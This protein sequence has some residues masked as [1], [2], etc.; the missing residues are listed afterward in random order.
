MLAQGGARASWRVEPSQAGGFRLFKNGDQIRRDGNGVFGDVDSPLRITYEPYGSVV[1]VADKSNDYE[2]GRLE[3]GLY[4]ST[5]CDSGFCLRLVVQLSMQKYLLGLAE[6]PSSWP[7]AVLRAQAMAGRTYA[8][9]KRER[10]GSHRYPCDCTVYDSTIDQAYAGNG[11]RVGSDGVQTPEDH[12]EDWSEA[13]VATDGKII[14]HNGDPIQALYSS[15]SGGHTENNENVWGG[16]PLPFLRGVPDKPDA[17]SINPNHR[18]DPVTLSWREFSA[19]V[20]ND[21]E[22]DSVGNLE[23]FRIVPPRGVSGR[24]TVTKSATEG[25][26]RLIGSAGTVRDSGWGF[27]TNFGSDILLDTLFYIEIKQTV[28]EQ[29]APT[30]RR[31]DGA[32]GDAL[33]A[34]Y[35]VPKGADKPLGR[36]QNFEIGRMTWRKATDKTVW[37]WGRVL[38]KY[39]NVGRERSRLGMPTSNVWGRE[40]RFWGGSYANG[41]IFWSEKTGA[42]VVRDAFFETFSEVGG[43]PRMGL[44]TTDVRQTE[45]NGRLQRFLNGTLYKPPRRAAVYALWGPIDERYRELGMGRSRCGFPTS[46]MVRDSSGAAV[47]FQNGSI[48]YSAGA[49]VKV[50]CD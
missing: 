32:P 30:Y 36:A 24:V 42:H 47:A 33:A 19:R 2:L 15:S 29:F 5:A 12:F 38:R 3:V 50:H 6:V 49:G 27:R 7:Q 4:S 22:Y 35:P 8:Y 16:T 9:D 28:G 34:P 10:S 23:D 25:G 44:P 1:D 20:E 40:G 26:V 14:T 18:W 21:S 31:L 37:Q 39:D 48:T 43:R 46:S 17:V 13:V 11:K 45:R 41:V